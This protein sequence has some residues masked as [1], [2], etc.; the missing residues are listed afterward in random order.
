MTEISGKAASYG[1]AQQAVVK[2]LRRLRVLLFDVHR[3]RAVQM[4]ARLLHFLA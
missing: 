1:E 4:A 3:E 2:S